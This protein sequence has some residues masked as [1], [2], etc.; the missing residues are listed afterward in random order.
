MAGGRP[1]K[2]K[3]EGRGAATAQAATT[4]CDAELWR[5][6]DAPRS[7]MD[8]GEYRQVVLG[9]TS[10]KYIAG[11]SSEMHGHLE[12]EHAQGRDREDPNAFRTQNI[13]FVASGA[14][15]GHIYDQTRQG[16]IGNRINYPRPAMDRD[17]PGSR[18][19]LTLKNDG[20]LL[21]SVL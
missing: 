8:A 16:I 7:S 5:I 1:R 18:A 3:G 19:V 12:S 14:R 4:G 10:L 21:R 6:A 20:I 13:L 15:Y 9:L 17:N 11:A 2:Q